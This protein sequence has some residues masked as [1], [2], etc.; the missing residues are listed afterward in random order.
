MHH[1]SNLGQLRASCRRFAVLAVL[2]VVIGWVD[3]LYAQTNSINTAEQ[4]AEKLVDTTVT[5]RVTPEQG[6]HDARAEA[7]VSV[8][9]GVSVGEG[10]IVTFV[11][12]PGA[13]RIRV[14]I[15]GDGRS[16]EAKLRAVDHYSGL[17]LIRVEN[18][19]LPAVELGEGNLKPGSALFTAAGAGMDDPLIS[20][21]ILGG[22]DRTVGAMLPPLMQCDLRTAGNSSGAPVVD[23]E[24][25]LQGIIVAT[26]NSGNR[27][28]WTYAVPARYIR[29]LLKAEP[30]VDVDGVV[31]LER[32]RPALGLTLAPGEKPGT[33]FVERVRPD[34]PAAEAGF[35]PG[36]QVIET[37]GRKVR[38]VY[39]AIA[40]VF[41]KQ[42]GDPMEFL[43]ERQ[44]EAHKLRLTLGNAGKARPEPLTSTPELG[45]GRTQ[46]VRSVGPN[47][48][49]I[50]E[51]TYG[52]EA[53]SPEEEPLPDDEAGLLREQLKR[54]SQAIIQLQGQIKQR[55]RQVEQLQQQIEELEK[56]IME[57]QEN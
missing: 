41:R 48:I 7:G 36:D 50:R 2:A 57:K 37:D 11:N 55:D 22:N 42:P 39:Q 3:S 12:A 51:L 23:P 27:A 34:G 20:F 45:I 46:N 14:T 28:G 25:K 18:E 54:W 10:R 43:V 1:F 17:S 40:L 47:Q 6:D 19:K 5:V 32:R 56:Q 38:S 16:L 35:K 26:E 13:S 8:A 15:P 24:G 49:E 53:E 33:L 4:V 52:Q 30:D 9:S 44:G 31:V 21:G 29:R